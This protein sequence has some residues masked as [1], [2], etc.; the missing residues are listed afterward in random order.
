MNRDKELL[1]ISEELRADF[2]KAME[3]ALVKIT[4]KRLGGRSAQRILSHGILYCW[5]LCLEQ[6]SKSR[7]AEL[8]E[9][10]LHHAADRILDIEKQEIYGPNIGDMKQ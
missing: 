1:K 10:G 4:D 3:A 9:E 6:L 5:I 7:R 2:L 8:F